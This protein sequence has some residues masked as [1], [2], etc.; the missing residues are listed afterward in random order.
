MFERVLRQV[1]AL[2]RASEY[3]PLLD[4]LKSSTLGRAAAPPREQPRQLSP[5]PDDWIRW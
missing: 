1:Q 4:L 5:L 3:V 2:V